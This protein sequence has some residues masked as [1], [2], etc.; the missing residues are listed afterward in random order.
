MNYEQ[1]SVKILLTISLLS[2]F[3]QY[4]N[5]QDVN[6]EWVRVMDANGTFPS[7]PM[8][9]LDGNG[10]VYTCGS[11]SGTVD[12]D[13]GTGVSNLTA[14]GTYD[15]FISKLDELGNF[16]WAKR[17]GGTGD[18][19]VA[20]FALDNAGNIYATGEF[21]GTVD[22]DPGPEIYNLTSSNFSNAYILK[23]DAHG[24]FNWAKQIGET[25]A[26]QTH[27]ITAD[28]NGDVYLT[29]GYGGTIDMDPG[30]SV[31]NLTSTGLSDIFILKLN[32]SGQF[33]WAKSIGSSTGNDY[34]LAITTD[35]LG[36]VHTTGYFDGMADFDPSSNTYN[37][38]AS[39]SVC[40][41]SKLNPSG[42]FIHAK[43]LGTQ[44]SSGRAIY[45]D[46][47]G[48]TYSTGVFYGTG[49]F[50][51]GE[52]I[53]NL[54]SSGFSDV[55]V[56]KLDMDGGFVWA[57]RMGG[58]QYDGG[59]AIVVDIE[60]NVYSSGYF[61]STADFDPGA[62]THYLTSAGD[63]DAFI[64]K[65]DPMGNFVWAIR[66]GGLYQ[67]VVTRIKLDGNGNIY[68]SGYFKGT[69][70]F[71]PGA[72]SYNLTAPTFG[73]TMFLLKLS[74]STVSGVFQHSSTNGFTLYPNPN[75]G[76]I[77]IKCDEIHDLINVRILSLL[78]SELARMHFTNTRSM[79]FE[80]DLPNGTYILEISGANKERSLIKFVNIN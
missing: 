15:I 16:Y 19:Y 29:G 78:G 64:S 41:I 5:G 25:N 49:D 72:G 52:E 44:I 6:L 47:E 2:V 34:G 12:F 56:S 71:D 62:G 13:P 43:K 32:A 74:Q 61:A 35:E 22:F 77:S 33:L 8:V 18:N 10:N 54:N 1:M 67:D 80:A 21:S 30:A 3:T 14:Q 79:Q 70:D 76:V 27:S 17:I 73:G 46:G 75:S 36:N 55:F 39:E 50:N 53:Y 4:L 24:N 11:F 58:G 69:V 63:N 37:L 9:E 31:Y 65:L 45:T 48:Y 40:F 23:L 20:S 38:S 51:P 7:I 42:S 60:G 68:A 59:G 28:G 26:L 66:L 57:K